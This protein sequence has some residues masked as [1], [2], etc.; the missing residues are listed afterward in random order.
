MSLYQKTVLTPSLEKLKTIE[1]CH[2][3]NSKTIFYFLLFF[4]LLFVTSKPFP[5]FLSPKKAFNFVGQKFSKKM[6]KEP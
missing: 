4:F 2:F 3:S 6:K 5:K 1:K